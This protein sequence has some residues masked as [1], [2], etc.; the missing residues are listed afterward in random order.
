VTI[1]ETAK[2]SKKLSQSGGQRGLFKRL[3]CIVAL[4]D[5]LHFPKIALDVKG[6]P[7]LL[8]LPLADSKS[9]CRRPWNHFSTSL[10]TRL[11][12]NWV[13]IGLIWHIWD[14]RTTEHDI[15]DMFGIYHKSDTT[16]WWHV[17]LGHLTLQH[18][19]FKNN[20]NEKITIGEL[21]RCDRA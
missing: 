12:W 7:P 15:C 11:Y 5:P 17:T 1:A 4:S 21:N 19:K 18:K 20:K 6:F 16:Y 8:F 2:S 9:V 3:V 14:T 13:Q 10:P